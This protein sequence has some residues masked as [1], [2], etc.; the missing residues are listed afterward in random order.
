VRL[1]QQERF[2]DMSVGKRSLTLIPPRDLHPGEGF[3][4]EVCFPGEGAPA[5]ATLLLVG[6]P[7]LFHRQA[8]VF[9]ASRPPG[10]YQ[11]EVREARVEAQQCREELRQCR[12][13]RRTPGGIS[14]VLVSGLME[15]HGIVRKN[16]EGEVVEPR[17]GP[18]HVSKIASY[19][20]EGRVAVKVLLEDG[21]GQA[22]EATRAVLRGPKGETLHP[23]PLWFTR[24]LAPGEP[25][26]VKGGH[27]IVEVVLPGGEEALDRYTLLLWDD[28]QRGVTLDDVTFPSH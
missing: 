28:A 11:Q 7:A 16:L 26:G 12:L 6:H 23:L 3:Q 17:D 8:E 5:C 10:A 1:S 27:I 21:Q 25:D 18:F 20:A 2:E 15:N 13:E 14:G 4:L 9:R 22:W 19:R 24:P